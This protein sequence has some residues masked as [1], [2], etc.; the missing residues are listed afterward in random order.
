MSLCPHI[1]DVLSLLSDRSW[2]IAVTLDDMM[3]TREPVK[4][5]KHQPSDTADFS[6]YIP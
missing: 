1:S 5:V 6:W 4:S 3:E 2:G